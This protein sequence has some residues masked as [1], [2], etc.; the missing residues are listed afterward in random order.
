M[1]QGVRGLPYHD[2]CQVVSNQK[3]DFVALQSVERR[4][5]LALALE[6]RHEKEL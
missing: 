6:R 2:G 1:N 3:R 5:R 4:I